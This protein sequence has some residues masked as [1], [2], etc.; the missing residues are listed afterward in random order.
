MDPQV[1]SPPSYFFLFVGRIQEKSCCCIL[2]NYNMEQFSIQSYTVFFCEK[3]RTHQDKTLHNIF[4]V[5]ICISFSCMTRRERKSSFLPKLCYFCKFWIAL[6]KFC[7][8]FFF[9]SFFCSCDIFCI[10]FLT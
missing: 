7:W 1:F 5:A 10:L 2:S 4:M 9:A 8:E 6:T 3:M